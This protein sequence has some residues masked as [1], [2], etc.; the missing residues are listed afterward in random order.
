MGGLVEQICEEE[1]IGIK[2][3]SDVY[4]V[5][6]PKGIHARPFTALHYVYEHYMNFTDEVED[7][8]LSYGK[9]FSVN[10]PVSSVFDCIG[11]PLI[12]KGQKV[13]VQ[14]SG[15]QQNIMQNSLNEFGEVIERTDGNYSS[16]FRK[17]SGYY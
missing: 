16:Y 9:L 10:I 2:K 5:G 3:V 12:L 7:I 6:D 4:V 1:G 11:L 13:Q 17:Y 8:K 14:V 15:L